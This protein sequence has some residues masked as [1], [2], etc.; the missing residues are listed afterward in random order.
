HIRHIAAA[1]IPGFTQ[2]TPYVH[3]GEGDPRFLH[4]YEFDSDDPEATFAS[5]PGLVAPR[6]GGQDSLAFEEWADLRAAGGYTV[7]VNT[8]AL[9]GARDVDD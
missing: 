2:I 9:L 1:G 5:M 3:E 7:Y 8:F 4:L 6:L